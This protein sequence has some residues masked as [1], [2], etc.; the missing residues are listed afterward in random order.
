MK[1]WDELELQIK[2]VRHQVVFSRVGW[3]VAILIVI[4]TTAGVYAL[5]QILN[6]QTG[7]K[8]MNAVIEQGKVA[9][10]YITNQIGGEYELSVTLETIYADS[11]RVFVA[12]S[13]SGTAP[14]N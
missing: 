14:A 9:E 11:N 8:G 2:P 13:A 1:L 7:D 10:L 6:N 3:L 12:I 5:D 4:M